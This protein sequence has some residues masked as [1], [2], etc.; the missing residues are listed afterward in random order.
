MILQLVNSPEWEKT[1]TSSIESTASGAALLPPDLNAKF[2]SKIKAN[3]IHGYGTSEAVRFLFYSWLRNSQ[4]GEFSQTLAITGS[5]RENSLPG[6]KPVEGSVGLLMPGL[7]ARIIREDG[8][9]GG[10]GDTGELW[11][12]GDCVFQ[13]YFNDEE[14]TARAMTKDGWFNTGDICTVDEKQNF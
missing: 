10:V 8:T 14:A 13:G 1:D 9:D 11:V 12:K 5:M 2:Q 7:E 3:L 6:Y 4:I